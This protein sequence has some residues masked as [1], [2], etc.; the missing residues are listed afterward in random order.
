MAR[1]PFF[2][3][4]PAPQIAR[5][6]MAAATA[7]GRTWR[8]TFQNL[9][10]IAASTIQDIDEKRKKK[11]AEEDF[12]LLANQ[13]P[14][15]AFS[16][17]G[18]EDEE[19]RKAFTD[20]IAKNPEVRQNVFD[21]V[22]FQQQQAVANQQLEANRIAMAE[23]A[24]QIEATDAFNRWAFKEQPGQLTPQAQQQATALRRFDPRARDFASAVPPMGPSQR[25]DPSGFVDIARQR[26][27]VESTRGPSQTPILQPSNRFLQSATE[28]DLSPDAMK[29]AYEFAQQKATQETAR[30]TARLSGL[31]S[32]E[33]VIQLIDKPTADLRK[34]FQA[35]PPVKDFNKVN[36]AYNKIK[37]SFA[38]LRNLNTEEDR[39]KA[40][41]ADMA[42][43]FSYMKILDPGSTV[44]EG[45]YASAQ[46]TTGLPGKL[47]NW[48]NKAVSGEILNDEQREAFQAMARNTA[49]AQF[50]DL[51]I[52]INLY[53]SIADK[54]EIDVSRVIPQ[55]YL[56][57]AKEGLPGLPSTGGG[58]GGGGAGGPVTTKSG[59]IIGEVEPIKPVQPAPTAPPAQPQAP[60]TAIEQDI[61][62]RLQI[63]QQPQEI[64]LWYQ[65]QGPDVHQQATDAYEKLVRRGVL[66]YSAPR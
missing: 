43:I 58:G 51:N 5:M 49:Q 12:R 47:R 38:A 22:K 56:T 18:I 37:S 66:P 2:G 61:R 3:R 65:Q 33:K 59:F 42:M 10:Q 45:E 60:T 26:S 31:E 19:G 13:L 21:L 46:Q 28:A 1:T 39:K 4:G 50:D 62:H 44:R 17:F 14:M 34:E 64:L 36:A 63:G 32:R 53:K 29:K 35:L 57:I 20:R 11:E 23:Q 25:L 54:K 27:A 6:D 48:F 30:D 40:A 15:G 24:K 52:Q 41:A 8:E 16:P 7:P 9:G 55:E